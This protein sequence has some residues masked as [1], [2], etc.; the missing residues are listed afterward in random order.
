MGTKVGGLRMQSVTL[1]KPH[2]PPPRWLKSAQDPPPGHLFLLLNVTNCYT[3]TQE[4]G[5]NLDLFLC[6]FKTWR[7]E[8]CNS[9]INFHQLSLLYF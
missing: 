6:I 4:I 1:M 8:L 5:V 2:L 9:E 7:Y 3:E